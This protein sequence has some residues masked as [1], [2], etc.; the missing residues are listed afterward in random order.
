MHDD[1]ELCGATAAAAI[2]NVSRVTIARFVKDGRLAPVG[3]LGGSKR[4]PFVFRVED[5]AQLAQER[6]A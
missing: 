1:D 3:R 4:S 5:V 6:A 2:L